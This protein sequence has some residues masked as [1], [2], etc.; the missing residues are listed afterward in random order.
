MVALGR[1]ARTAPHVVRPYLSD[2]AR[3]PACDRILDDRHVHFADRPG[4]EPRQLPHHLQRPHVSADPPP[5]PPPGLAC[6]QNRCRP[7]AS[8]RLF[9]SPPLLPPP[10][11]T[12]F[13]SPPPS[14]FLLS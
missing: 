8:S 10:S 13:R 7:C 4:L 3:P 9:P 14:P 5:H 6:P 12:S 11:H 1:P 2:C